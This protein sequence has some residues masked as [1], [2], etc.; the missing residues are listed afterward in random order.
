M[1]IFLGQR[2]EFGGP[3]QIAVF[4]INTFHSGVHKRLPFEPTLLYYGIEKRIKKMFLIQEVNEAIVKA[5][6]TLGCD[7]P[8]DDQRDAISSF[9][10]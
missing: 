9:L 10:S 5:V 8:S 1:T 3:N 4:V 7:Q 2:Q 6:R